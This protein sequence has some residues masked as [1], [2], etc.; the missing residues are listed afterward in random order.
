M[1]FIYCLLQFILFFLNFEY[2]T[3]SS[4]QFSCHLGS[5]SHQK[6]LKTW[7][8]PAHLNFVIITVQTTNQEVFHSVLFF[9]A[10]SFC[11]M[12][13]TIPDARM[14]RNRQ[15]VTVR[16][17]RFAVPSD[18]KIRGTTDFQASCCSHYSSLYILLSLLHSQGIES[19]VLFTVTY[20]LKRPGYTHQSRSHTTSLAVPFFD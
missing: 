15:E 13:W 8:T 2:N 7:S 16:I 14:A 4:Q 20:T 1:H 12:G 19:K 10:C 18:T 11:Y 9:S 5:F 6:L 17:C 3:F